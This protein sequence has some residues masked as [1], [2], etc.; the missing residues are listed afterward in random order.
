MCK[1]A[2]A[3]FLKKSIFSHKVAFFQLSTFNFQ[4]FF[5]PL[6]PILPKYGLKTKNNNKK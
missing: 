6:H 5:V 1:S 2:R 3:I 4:L